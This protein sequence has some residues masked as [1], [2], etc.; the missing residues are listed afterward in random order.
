M[1]IKEWLTKA[2]DYSVVVVIFFCIIMAAQMCQNTNTITTLVDSK[3]TNNGLSIDTNEKILILNKQNID[4]NKARLGRI[5]W[6]LDSLIH[7][8][9]VKDSLTHAK[10]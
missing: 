2:S 10:K 7:A 1:K 9:K 5:E 4:T 8:K 3:I 6:K